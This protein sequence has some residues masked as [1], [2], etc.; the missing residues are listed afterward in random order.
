[1]IS[2]FERF[3]DQF[4]YGPLS[5]EDIKTI[6]ISHRILRLDTGWYIGV[7]EEIEQFKDFFIPRPV[8]EINAS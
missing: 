2:I 8:E 6:V 5:D 3:S 4:I 1:M 7:N